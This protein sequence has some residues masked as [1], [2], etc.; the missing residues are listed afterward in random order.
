MDPSAERIWKYVLANP[1][2][3]PEEIA[4]WTNTSPKEVTE[5]LAKIGTPEDIWR[6]TEVGE[7]LRA[8]LLAEA[9]SITCGPREQVYGSP[10]DNMRHIADIFNART[11]RTG[12]RA[13]SAREV[14]ILLSSVKQARRFTS[15]DHRDSYVDDM[16]YTGIEYECALAED[17]SS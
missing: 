12:D 11:R 4:A 2:A 16:A 9:S 7:P 10:V 13:I 1:K 15:N 14:T 17:T 3:T 5:L 8:Q 6:K